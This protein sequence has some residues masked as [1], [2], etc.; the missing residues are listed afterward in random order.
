MLLL[1]GALLA[2]CTQSHVALVEAMDLIERVFHLL[3]LHQRLRQ[4]PRP[5][6][7]AAISPVAERFCVS[8]KLTVSSPAVT[9]EESRFQALRP[10]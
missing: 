2:L 7:A 10:T 5:V 8:E 1:L 3:K 6:V 9:S 4:K